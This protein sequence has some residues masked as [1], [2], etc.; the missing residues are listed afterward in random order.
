MKKKKH[1]KPTATEQLVE[2]RKLLKEIEKEKKSIG[3]SGGK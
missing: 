2:I 1:V 3:Q